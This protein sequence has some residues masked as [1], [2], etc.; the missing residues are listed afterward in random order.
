VPKFS[1]GVSQILGTRKYGACERADYQYDQ[2]RLVQVLEHCFERSG[3]FS[4]EE[5]H[6]VGAL[7]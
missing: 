2:T 1:I 4:Y 6:C 3:G 5:F 7:R